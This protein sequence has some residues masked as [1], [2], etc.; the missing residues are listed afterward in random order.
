MYEVKSV[1]ERT[2]ADFD[3][4]CAALLNDGWTWTGNVIVITDFDETLKSAEGL[5]YYQ[6]YQKFS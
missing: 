3:S 1:L 4:Y 2:K 5:I 6:Q